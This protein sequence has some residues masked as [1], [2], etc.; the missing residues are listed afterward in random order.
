MDCVL[1][2]EPERTH[3]MNFK[4]FTIKSQEALQK[5]AEIA[6]GLQQQAIEPRH[7]LK[8]IFETDENVTAY[9]TKKLAVN[10]SVLQTRL[11][12]LLNSYPKVSG[13]QPYLS[14]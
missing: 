2:K 3:F 4:K 8:A 1:W 12:E 6:M 11:E 7:V 9:L 13:Q 14:S 5:S 10:T